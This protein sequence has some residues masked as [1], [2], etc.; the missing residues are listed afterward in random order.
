MS[1][2]H[3]IQEIR[4]SVQITW[5]PEYAGPPHLFSLPHRARAVAEKLGTEGPTLFFCN[6]ITAR[7]SFLLQIQ[8]SIT[9]IYKL[10]YKLHF[11]MKM[12]D[13]NNLS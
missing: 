2:K 5:K 11:A 7:N 12:Y 4:I 9:L 6:S 1:T 10:M 3:F 8:I 13:G